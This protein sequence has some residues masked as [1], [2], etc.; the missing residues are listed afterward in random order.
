MRPQDQLAWVLKALR[1]SGS[2]TLLSALG[3]AIG[4]AAVTTL[5]GIG[6]GMR[7]YLL[8]SFS[9]FG[10]RVIAITPGVS[11]NPASPNGLLASSRPLTLNDGDLLRRLPH[12]Q[13]AIPVLSGTGQVKAGVLSRNTSI[14]GTN[15]EAAAGW[16]FTLARGHFL[17]NEPPRQARALAVL[18]HTLAQ[19][20]FADRPA[21]GAQVRIGDRRFRVVGVM[22]P[23]GQ[24]LG[25]DLDDMIFIPAG[26][27]QALFNREDLMEI[28]LIYDALIPTQTLLQQVEQRLIQHHG[29]RDF[30]LYS[31]EDMLGSLDKILRILSLAIGSLGTVSLLIGAVG[32]FTIMTIAQAERLT[33]IGLLR[34]LG[35]PPALILSLFLA[36]AVVLALL[37]GLLGLLLWGLLA[38]ILHGL[39]PGLPLDWQARYLMLAL[40]FSALVGLT[41][42]LLP[43]LRAMGLDPVAALRDE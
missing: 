21:L 28:D 32:I 25:F 29:R 30:T 3:I 42:G 15:H 2:R 18:G 10:S 7:G 8:E 4:I 35:A 24:F 1:R 43:A 14:L 26:Q 17:P 23:K 12:V 33:E 6:E 20:L 22:A 40:G 41:A 11:D 9:Q 37:G 5:T 27:A 19:E 31:Q 38:L 36:E 39:W 34:A 13:A 16:R